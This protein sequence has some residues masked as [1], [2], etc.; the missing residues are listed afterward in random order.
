MP[1]FITQT[2][3][4]LANCKSRITVWVLFAP[5]THWYFPFSLSHSRK[6]VWHLELRWGSLTSIS[7]WNGVNFL[8]NAKN[9]PRLINY[10]IILI[11]EHKKRNRCTEK[12]WLERNQAEYNARLPLLTYTDLPRRPFISNVLVQD[13]P[14][15]CVKIIYRSSN[16]L[17]PS[18]MKSY[19]RNDISNDYSWGGFFSNKFKSK[20]LTASVRSFM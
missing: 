6:L 19:D 16:T 13:F 11:F 12:A 3:N 18:P 17:A 2:K 9:A 5:A 8:T 4:L 10:N 1:I 20:W 15:I 7:F 14:I